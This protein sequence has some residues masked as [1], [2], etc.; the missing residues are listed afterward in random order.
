MKEMRKGALGF[1]FL[2]GGE[3]EREVRESMRS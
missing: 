2:L 1:G 3:G